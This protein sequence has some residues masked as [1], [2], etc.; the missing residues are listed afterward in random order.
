MPA[1]P[2]PDEIRPVELSELRAASA[3]EAP[4]VR[5]MPRPQSPA[6]PSTVPAAPG[7]KRIGLAIAGG[8]VAA[9]ALAVAA[10]IAFGPR[11]A[12]DRDE[13]D[14]GSSQSASGDR[15]A[16]NEG[17][18]RTDAPETSTAAEAPLSARG[19]KP[20]PIPAKSPASREVR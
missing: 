9:G 11:G 16:D 4:R 5:P 8:V 20:P 3:R 7:K 19:T 15:P 12:D 17:T 1:P 18:D 14:N 13:T 10:G 6:A 2:D